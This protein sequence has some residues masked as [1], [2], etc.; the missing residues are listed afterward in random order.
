MDL[1]HCQEDGAV[2]HDAAPCML[3][4]DIEVELVECNTVY[5]LLLP[6]LLTLMLILIVIKNYYNIACEM[7]YYIVIYTVYTCI[8][9]ISSEK[10]QELSVNYD[11]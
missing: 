5:F 3:L 1:L 6:S 9:N 2:G 8:D 11:S 7:L 10:K 4:L